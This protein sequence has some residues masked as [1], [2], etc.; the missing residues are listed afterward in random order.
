MIR[1]DYETSKRL[2]KRARMLR[3]RANAAVTTLMICSSCHIGHRF[4]HF[5]RPHLTAELHRFATCFSAVSKT[6]VLICLVHL[7]DP[8][9][10]AGHL[11]EILRVIDVQELSLARTQ[12]VIPT[13]KTAWLWGQF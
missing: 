7:V 10:A 8:Q 2:T 13:D 1:A 5:R 4:T 6:K 11:V 12:L 3:L 9:P